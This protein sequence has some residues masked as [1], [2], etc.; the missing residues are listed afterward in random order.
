[1]FYRSL[2]V[3]VSITLAQFLIGCG[4]LEKKISEKMEN[5]AQEEIPEEVNVTVSI[6]ETEDYKTPVVNSDRVSN[7]NPD[8]QDGGYIPT[9][10][11]KRAF[12][13][14]P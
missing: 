6:E 12:S 8:N 9:A 4:E 7:S 13:Y 10:L 11:S 2:L 1:M 5:K 3:L 14:N